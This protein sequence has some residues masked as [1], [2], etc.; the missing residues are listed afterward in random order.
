M[1]RTARVVRR[2]IRDEEGATLL[3]YGILVML[4]AVVSIAAVKLMGSKISGTFT[5]ANTALP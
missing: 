1:Y 5:A 2:L 4:I 3:E